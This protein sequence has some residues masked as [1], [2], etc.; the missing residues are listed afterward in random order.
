MAVAAAQVTAFQQSAPDPAVVV[1]AIVTHADV[2][3]QHT[4]VSA[5]NP[6][7]NGLE[8]TLN[9]WGQNSIG[10]EKPIQVQYHD[11]TGQ[12]FT[13]ASAGHSRWALLHDLFTVFYSFW[14]LLVSEQ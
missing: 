13:D 3:F 14:H 5:M 9:L 2:Y 7:T 8:A 12:T 6:S 4:D 10:V 1:P 11:L